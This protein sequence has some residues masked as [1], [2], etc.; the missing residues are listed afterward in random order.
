MR[1][2]AAATH[3]EKQIWGHTEPASVESIADTQLNSTMEFKTGPIEMEELN[4]ALKKFKRRKA[5]GPDEIPMEFF[6]ELDATNRNELLNMLNEWWVNENMPPEVCRARVVMIFKKGDSSK[7]DNY[8]PISL[9]NATY[10]IFSA[11]TE[12]DS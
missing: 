11:V 6:K 5:P 7:M 8:R 4:D 9:L 2:E 12:K 1:A 3:L 10:S